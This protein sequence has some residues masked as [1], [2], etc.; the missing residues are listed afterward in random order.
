MEGEIIFLSLKKFSEVALASP[1][2]PPP[3][4]CY[5]EGIFNA[6]NIIIF[7]SETKYIFAITQTIVFEQCIR[8]MAI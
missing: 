1:C 5:W 3:Q 2:P 6:N 4:L 7:K 8:K